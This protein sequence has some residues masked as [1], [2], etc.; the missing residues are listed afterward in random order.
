[1]IPD[2]E[3]HDKIMVVADEHPDVYAT[4][5][6]VRV[7]SEG[8]E[9]FLGRSG[10][11]SSRRRNFHCMINQVFNENCLDTMGRMPDKYVDMVLTSPPYDSLRDYH[12]EAS[13]MFVEQFP[14]IIRELFRVIK[15]GGV[16]VWVVGR[17]HRGRRGD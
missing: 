1:M 8:S 4:L 14:K 10:F 5:L 11:T 2:F 6:G 3:S 12:D 15:E 17:R 7:E 9:M 13:V 16:M